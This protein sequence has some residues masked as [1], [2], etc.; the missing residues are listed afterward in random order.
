VAQLNA[1]RQQRCSGMAGEHVAAIV[2][3]Y[4]SV[5]VAD[6]HGITPSIHEKMQL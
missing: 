5:V 3:P 6:W 4:D 1:S 2:S